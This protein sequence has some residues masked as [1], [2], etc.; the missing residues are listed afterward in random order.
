VKI[1]IERLILALSSFACPSAKLSDFLFKLSGAKNQIVDIDELL[2][3]F[4]K[5]T[6]EKISSCLREGVDQKIIEICKDKKISPIFF[7]DKDY[8]SALLEIPDFPP[9]I[10]VAGNLKL[11]SSKNL[12][13]VVGSRRPSQYGICQ[14]KKFVYE[15][16]QR[17]GEIVS[18][19][20]FGIDS[21]AHRAC[22]ESKRKTIAVLGTAI[23]EIY[24]R[25]NALLAQEILSV[26]GAIVSEY[27]PGRE[28]NKYNFA[29]RNRII[30]G[31]A[32]TTLVMEASSNSGSLIT[33]N[34][35]AQYGRT[36][37]ALPGNVDSLLS[38]GTNELIREGA[39]ALCTLSDIDF[40][41]PAQ[42]DEVLYKGDPLKMGIV[43]KLK[44]ASMTI[45]EICQKTNGAETAKVAMALSQM[46]I[47][48]IV[49]VD[50]AGKYSFLLKK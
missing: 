6:C 38:R 2:N 40:I 47:D 5:E 10:Y 28:G 26:S 1:S 8:P 34:L 30:A 31:L 17:G 50:V 16:C 21:V 49:R 3:F 20:A 43:E 27:P 25:S 11:L 12:V 39:F 41:L 13:S 18:G 33:A 23:D 15:I 19:L 32:N 36:V 44:S 9:I 4:K 24:P 22:L 37:Y 35:A 42:N 7:F 45:D 46:E 14:T 29:L 48:K